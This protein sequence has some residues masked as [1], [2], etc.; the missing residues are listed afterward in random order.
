[1]GRYPRGINL[2]AKVKPKMKARLLVRMLSQIQSYA[3]RKVSALVTFKPVNVRGE[4]TVHTCTL[5]GSRTPHMV[6]K[7]LAKA[8]ITID[9]KVETGVAGLRLRLVVTVPKAQA[10]IRNRSVNFI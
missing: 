7:G 9:P 5:L 8:K 6:I 4:R 2:G 10:P 1:M 3:K